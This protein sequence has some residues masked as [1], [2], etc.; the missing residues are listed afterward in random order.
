MIHP[1]EAWQNT[2]HPPR[3]VHTES[4]AGTFT[5]CSYIALTATRE[6]PTIIETVQGNIQHSESI[7]TSATSYALHVHVAYLHYAKWHPEALKVLVKYNRY[8]NNIFSLTSHRE[9]ITA[10]YRSHGAHPS[11]KPG[12][13]VNESK[14]ISFNL[15][16]KTIYFA[17][18]IKRCVG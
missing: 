12:F 16:S 7:Q 15:K 1:I 11:P 4:F 10:V 9:K 14:P 13:C 5:N 8:N 18:V 17:T 2:Y 3:Y 6:K